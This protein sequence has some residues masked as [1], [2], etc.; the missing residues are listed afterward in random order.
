MPAVLR[1][2][3]RRLADVEGS[4]TREMFMKSRLVF[5][6]FA[7]ALALLPALS[8]ADETR[9]EVIRVYALTEG[10]AVAVAV[11]A[12]WQDLSETGV[13]GRTG[14]RFADESGVRVQISFSELE[15]A[16]ANKRVLRASDAK[17]AVLKTPKPL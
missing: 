9:W 12:E 16:S 5:S 4:T 2:K 10:R 8:Q 17:R 11:P 6:L 13:L 15:R 14:L 1:E 3:Q 7:A